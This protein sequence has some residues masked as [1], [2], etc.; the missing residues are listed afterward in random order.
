MTVNVL[1]PRDCMVCGKH[2]HI[3]VDEP[4][5][6]RWRA[7]E[8]IQNVWPEKTAVE[9]EALITGICSQE[10]WDKLWKE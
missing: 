5:Y 2:Y 9:R 7:G 4:R 10:C 8:L 6:K 3:E 1:V